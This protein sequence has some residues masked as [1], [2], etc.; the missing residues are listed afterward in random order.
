[1]WDVYRW[2][3]FGLFRFLERLDLDFKIF[4]KSKLIFG[5]G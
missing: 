4:K 3:K 2:I 5:I 1:M